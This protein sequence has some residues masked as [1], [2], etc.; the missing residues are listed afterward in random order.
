[1]TLSSTGLSR[2]PVDACPSRWQVKHTSSINRART[3]LGGIATAVMNA[4]IAGQSL[5]HKDGSQTKECAD[6]N[7]LSSL[8]S[9]LKVTRARTF[10]TA[11]VGLTVTLV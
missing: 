10:T 5:T 4:S 8:K 6:A 9:I 7:Q 2:R 11:N 1:M 3:S